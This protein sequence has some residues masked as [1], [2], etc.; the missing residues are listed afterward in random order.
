ML[1]T[2]IRLPHQSGAWEIFNVR[3]NQSQFDA[4]VQC[5]LEEYKQ[6]LKDKENGEFE[7]WENMQS[8]K[9]ASY[10][11]IGE[12][13]QETDQMM[14]NRPEMGL[15]PTSYDYLISVEDAFKKWGKFAPAVAV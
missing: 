2:L 9:V 3:N 4:E 14:A 1:R 8:S 7:H 12:L 15:R 10:R 13:R 5:F 11:S 6:F